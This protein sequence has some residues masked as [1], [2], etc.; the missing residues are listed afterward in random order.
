M[1][2]KSQ[3]TSAIGLLLIC[4]GYGVVASIYSGKM[5]AFSVS[6]ILEYSAVVWM[7]SGLIGAIIGASFLFD[8]RKIHLV[9]IVWLVMI[10]FAEIFVALR[11]HSEHWLI[12]FAAPETALSE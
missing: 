7:I 6:Q 11:L 4:V 1:Q 10:P 5:T 2:Y 12:A 9:Y 3:M 8:I